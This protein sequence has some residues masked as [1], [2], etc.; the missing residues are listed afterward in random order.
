MLEAP[1]NSRFAQR[2]K[3]RPEPIESVDYSRTRS[4]ILACLDRHGKRFSSQSPTPLVLLPSPSLPSISTPPSSQPLT[5][6]QETQ[7][8]LL[9]ADPI[10][11]LK[12]HKLSQTQ[13]HDALAT[14][15]ST[16][17]PPPPFSF[18]TPP[19]INLGTYYIRKSSEKKLE[20]R[21]RVTCKLANVQM[22]TVMESKLAVK[23]EVIVML[24]NILPTLENLFETKVLLSM[25]AKT[26]QN[27]G[28]DMSMLGR[29]LYRVTNNVIAALCCGFK[30][31]PVVES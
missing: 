18:L 16:L 6:V 13:V 10:L 24:R 3:S 5:K 9:Q 15:S 2:C 19:I 8:S 26:C 27:D 22:E 20:V 21:L 4:A 7:A 29:F 25:M 30:N 11:Q 14:K 17:T 1:T 28:E 31:C 12:A 23:C